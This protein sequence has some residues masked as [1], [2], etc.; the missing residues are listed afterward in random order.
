MALPAMALAYVTGLAIAPWLAPP[1]SLHY[2]PWLLALGW[3]L[4]RRLRLAPLLLYAALF[5]LGLNLYQQALQP[6]AGATQLH[7]LIGPGERILEGTVIARS[8]SPQGESLELEATLTGVWPILTPAQGTVRLHI[9]EGQPHCLPG[10]RIRVLAR[11]R[12]P[13]QFGTPGEFNYPRHLA[14]KGIFVTGSVEEARDIVRLGPDPQAPLTSWI[15][16]QRARLAQT[17]EQTVPA[18]EASLVRALTIGDS[19]GISAIQRDLLSRGGVSHLFAISGLHLGLIALGL[20]QLVRSLYCRSETLLL[21]APPRRFLPLCLLPILAFYTLFT[22]SGLATQRA[23][24]M[25][26]AAALLLV[27]ARRTPPLR[28]LLLAALLLLWLAP[29]SLFEP[30]FQLSCAGVGGL[31]TLLPRWQPRISA[32]PRLLRWPAGL[33]AATI[34]ATIATTPI[35]LWHFHI[36]APAGLLANLVAVPMIGFGAVPL[37]LAGAVV[38]PFSAA[39]VE[40]CLQLCGWVVFLTLQLVEGILRWPGLAGQ[41]LLLTPLQLLGPLLLATAVLTWGRSRRLTLG[42]VVMASLL[43]FTKFPAENLLAVTALSVGQGDATLLSIPGCGHLLIDGGGLYGDSFDTGERLVA[44]A[45]ARLGVRSL[46]AVLLTHNHP[47][48]FKGLPFILEHFPVREF[49]SA[50]PLEELDQRLQWPLTSHDIPLRQF[51][52]GWSQIDCGD[53]GE[54]QLFVPAQ[55]QDQ[56]DRSVVVLARFGSDG[57]LLPGDLESEG[58]QELLHQPLPA[59]INLLKLPHHGSRHSAPE[60][61]LESI[62]PKIAFVSA[63]VDNPHKLPHREVVELYTAAKIPL[64]RTDR[65]GSLQFVSNGSGWRASHYLRGLFR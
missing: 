32:L 6:P 46:E 63:G 40:L 19:R 13:R 55:D 3:F 42:L 33:L 16:R 60:L 37:A 64:Y 51:S 17:I 26:V 53:K 4:T 61:V 38:E 62:H 15:S 44:P 5:T 30:G 57:V 27:L 48:H 7:R 18:T 12:Q 22:G 31:L 47:D 49:W 28:L 14:H 58:L 39:A 36:L 59:A 9:R 65:M 23:L 10:E 34:A 20:Y 52:P 41:V 54:L 21:M 35:V 45:L 25:C 29:L 50:M 8:R 1:A 56:N 43:A 11:L 2:W 24:L